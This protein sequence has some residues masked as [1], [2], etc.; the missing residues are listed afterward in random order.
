MEINFGSKECNVKI[1]YYGPGLS[2]KTTNLEVIHKKT[3]ETNRGRLTAL[4]TDM[5]RTLFF[6]YMPLELGKING[7]NIRIRLFTVPGQVYY[8]ATRKLVLRCVDGVVFVAD[9]QKERQEAN[10]ESLTNLADNLK[11]QGFSIE[12]IPLV[13][14]FNKRDLNDIMSLETMREEMN[15][16]LKAPYF[17]AV[18]VKGEGVYQCLKSITNLTMLKVEQNVQKNARITQKDLTMVEERK[19]RATVSTKQVSFVPPKSKSK[20]N[21][22]TRK[23]KI[24]RKPA[25]VLG[26]KN[27]NNAKRFT[28]T[29]PKPSEQ[30]IPKQIINVAAKQEKKTDFVKKSMDQYS[31]TSQI[32]ITE[33]LKTFDAT[34][35]KGPKFSLGFRN[36]NLEELLKETYDFKRDIIDIES[37]DSKKII[38]QSGKDKLTITLFRDKLSKSSNEK[39]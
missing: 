14:Q 26:L 10:I 36:K 23:F 13:L 20:K 2:G 1:V 6:D 32:P 37:C 11:E 5:D 19:K 34:L 28:L 29:K 39:N 18:A 30:S 24:K 35:K 33:R 22:F 9:S 3:P 7:L 38:L 16:K 4:A 27:K 15:N 12:D 17:P 21:L 8:N 31:Q 25:D